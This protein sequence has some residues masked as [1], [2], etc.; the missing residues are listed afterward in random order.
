M[1]RDMCKNIQR[2]FALDKTHGG[3]TE[4]NEDPLEEEEEVPLLFMSRTIVLSDIDDIALNANEATTYEM[5]NATQRVWFE[6]VIPLVNHVR[7]VPT[8]FLQCSYFSLSS[9][10]MMLR[11]DGRSGET[12]K[13]KNKPIAITVKFHS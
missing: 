12:H 1:K 2:N 9:D 6:K 10:E 4:E 3:E 8:E 13:M 7:S 11:L 5:L